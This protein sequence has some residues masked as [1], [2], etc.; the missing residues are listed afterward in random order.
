M[1]VQLQ[2][3][4]VMKIFPLLSSLSVLSLPASGAIVITDAGYTGTFTA[5][6][7]E[8]I[9]GVTTLASITTAEGTFSALTGAISSTAAGQRIYKGADLLNDDLTVVGLSASDGLLNLTS[10]PTVFQFGSSFT[11][12]TRFF[13]IDATSVGG[14]FG[15]T[16]TITLVDATGAAVGTYTFG[17]TAANFGTNLGTIDNANRETNVAITLQTSGTSFSLAD[18]TGTGDL[19]TATGI[20]LTN[21]AGLDPTVVGIYTVPEPGALALL[22]LSAGSLL[23][24]RHRKN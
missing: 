17:L 13:I 11:A 10:S 24:R 5:G 21:A 20:R 16:A 18:F 9:T 3:L 23:F 19:S 4:P 22:G 15:D 6:T 2:A 8:T 12:A 14:G 7:P 1:I